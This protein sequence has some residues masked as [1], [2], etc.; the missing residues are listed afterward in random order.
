MS[1]SEERQQA[2]QAI[3]DFY[4]PDETQIKKLRAI[5]NNE[6]GFKFTYKETEQVSYQLLMLYEELA[7]GQSIRSEEHSHGYRE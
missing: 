6:T 4:L 3:N 5:I 1:T 7:R 2:E